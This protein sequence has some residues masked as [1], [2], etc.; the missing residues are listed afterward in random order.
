MLPVAEENKKILI[1]EPAVADP[2]T[3]DK[4]NRYIFRTARNSTQDA[5]S[6]AVAI[7][8]PGDGDRDAGAGLCLRPRRRRRVQG[9]AGRD[10]R[11]ARFEEYAPPTGDR[12]HGRRLSAS[13]MR[14]R[15]S[16]A[17]RSSVIIWAGAASDGQDQA[18]KP[19][20]F[21]IE[22]S[23]GGNILAAMKAYK[24]FPGME[25]AHLLLLRHPQE[26]D[27]RLAGRRAQEALQ[28][29]ARLLHRRRHGL[30][31]AMVTAL[32]K[33]K[34]TD[35]ELIAA[36]EGMAFDTPKGPMTFRKEDHQALQ[37][38]YHFKIRAGRRGID[39]RNSWENP[40][41]GHAVPVERTLISASIPRRVRSTRTRIS[42]LRSIA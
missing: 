20:R 5:I 25:G 1:V 16:R 8:K 39:V 30:R 4:W 17:A 22:I 12:F 10:R 15:T 29:A 23:P 26:P 2:I 3:G 41:R 9:G 21:G 28:R 19:E 27:E 13:S 7:G 31:H 38:M 40:I 36:M 18:I 33:A 42:R 14:S 35:R 11:E 32:K 6:N 34:S 37:S 24:T